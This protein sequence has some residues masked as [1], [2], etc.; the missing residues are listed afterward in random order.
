MGKAGAVRV[1]ALDAS[2][3]SAM[4]RHENRA[5]QA[6]KLRMKR[7]MA[8]LVYSPHST[9]KRLAEDFDEALSQ[10]EIRD[11]VKHLSISDALAHHIKGARRNRAAKKQCLHALVQFPTDLEVDQSSEAEMLAEA[12]CFINF[13]HGHEAVFHARL[14]RDEAGRHV[15]DVF[16]APRYVKVTKRKSEDWVSLTKFGKELARSKIGKKPQEVRCPKTGNWSTVMTAAGEPKMVWCDSQHHQG[17]ALQQVWHEHLVDHM[18]LEWAVRGSPKMGRDP[19]RLE[20]EEYKIKSEKEKLA[21]AKTD[22]EAQAAD[23]EEKMNIATRLD[24]AVELIFAEEPPQVQSSLFSD[25]LTRKCYDAVPCPL[26]G[27]DPVSLGPIQ[28][29]FYDETRQRQMMLVLEPENRGAEWDTEVPARLTIFEAARWW[30]DFERWWV[31]K[32]EVFFQ[33]EDGKSGFRQQLKEA[34]RSEQWHKPDR[35]PVPQ[36]RHLSHVFE[37]IR[38]LRKQIFQRLKDQ[39]LPQVKMG[40]ALVAEVRTYF[41]FVPMQ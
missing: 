9:G 15:V 25:S 30:A 1:K 37:P 12:V 19:D 21:A 13:Q 33:G 31:H 39:I 34:I 40:K 8:A 14:D 2:Q 36:T 23:L 11:P 16:Y 6:A 18:E 38:E 41:G 22:L 5:D 26:W 10:V 27:D 7:D 4:E 35:E 3:V 20:V 24:A 17:Q 29:H 32:L 28:E